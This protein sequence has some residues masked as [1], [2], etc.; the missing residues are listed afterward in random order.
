MDNVLPFTLAW[1]FYTVSYVLI[2]PRL[3]NTELACQASIAR[4]A[5]AALRSLQTAQRLTI[6]F[7]KVL[8]K[9]VI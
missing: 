7:I 3:D 8:A 6:P 5:T 4:A 9:W 1:Q 2:P